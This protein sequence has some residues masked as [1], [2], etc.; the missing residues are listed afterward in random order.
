VPVQGGRLSKNV[1]VCISDKLCQRKPKGVMCPSFRAN[2]LWKSGT[3]V[4]E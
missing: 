2:S 1:A 3:A 4:A